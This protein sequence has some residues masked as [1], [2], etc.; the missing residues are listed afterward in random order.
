MN[1][2]KKTLMSEAL[3]AY[4]YII[5]A[6][7]EP[8]QIRGNTTVYPK[9]KA[10]VMKLYLD[11]FDAY[12]AT[13]DPVKGQIA[14]A[15][16]LRKHNKTHGNGNNPPPSGGSG[17]GNSGSGSGGRPPNPPGTNVR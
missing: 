17:S 5:G 10:K 13:K 14:A 6:D 3:N 9:A 4:G 11:M 2:V 8:Q 7:G 15:A 12:K 1:T 16:V